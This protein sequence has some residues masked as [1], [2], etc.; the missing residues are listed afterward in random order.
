MRL[1][2]DGFGEEI[3]LRLL[4]AQEQEYLCMQPS[5]LSTSEKNLVWGCIAIGLIETL[6]P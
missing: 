6:L 3:V 4:D 1:E 5:R 2:Y